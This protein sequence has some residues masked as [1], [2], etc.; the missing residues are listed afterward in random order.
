M[1]WGRHV[2]PIV[3]GADRPNARNE[4]RLVSM[5]QERAGGPGGPYICW[6][7]QT[8]KPQMPTTPTASTGHIRIASTAK[9]RSSRRRLVGG[10]SMIRGLAKTAPR[11][12]D[13]RRVYRTTEGRPIRDVTY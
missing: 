6:Y 5:G 10:D 8:V 2:S 12:V 13:L 7:I 4:R 1:R 3:T 11:D 9:T